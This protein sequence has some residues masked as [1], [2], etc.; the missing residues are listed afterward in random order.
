MSGLEVEYDSHLLGSGLDDGSGCG[1]DAV[2]GLTGGLQ[3]EHDC[4]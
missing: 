1:E 4:C 3:L 2:G